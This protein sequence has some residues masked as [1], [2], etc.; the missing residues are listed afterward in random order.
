MR[1]ILHIFPT[2]AHRNEWMKQYARRHPKAVLQLSKARI[3]TDEEAHVCILKGSMLM[4]V[5]GMEF[6]EYMLH[7]VALNPA[8][9]ALLSTRIRQ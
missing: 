3:M 2:V 5:M 7:G 9:E 6:H 8:E 4:S 1:R